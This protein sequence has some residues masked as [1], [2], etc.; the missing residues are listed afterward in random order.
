MINCTFTVKT[1]RNFW[2]Q[3]KR[4]QINSQLTVLVGITFT[5]VQKLLI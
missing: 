1:I 5:D 4:K 2:N 3:N